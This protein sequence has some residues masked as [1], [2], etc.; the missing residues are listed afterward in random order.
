MA[1]ALEYL[2]RNADDHDQARRQ[3]HGA[4]MDISKFQELYFQARELRA[5]EDERAKVL[6][7]QASLASGAGA[8]LSAAKKHIE[9]EILCLRCP[10]KGCRKVFTDY[11]GCSKLTC[12]TCSTPFCAFCQ[13]DLTGLPSSV[14]HEHVA[15][16]QHNP[17]DDFF[18]PLAE[19]Q[20][21]M[22]KIK[23]RRVCAFVA[24]MGRPFQ[25]EVMGHAVQVTKGDAVGE[26]LELAASLF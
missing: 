5:A 6:Q 9:E 23:A 1:R 12:S 8:L 7:E 3:R 24:S 4:W 18:V 15:Q 16:C 11:T 17:S 10:R 2:T 20:K 21:A 26:H 22:D 13:K 25:C 14:A 19:W